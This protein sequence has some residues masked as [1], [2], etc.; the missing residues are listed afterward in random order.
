MSKVDI[1]AVAETFRSE[2]KSQI[3]KSGGKPKLVAFLCSKD[4]S[5]LQYAEFTKK[6][7]TRDGIEFV[8]QEVARTDLE[9]KII[10]ANEDSSIHGILVYYPVFGGAMDFYL[11]DVVA[12]EKDVEGMNNRCRFNLY[13]NI[14]Y[15]DEAKTKKCILPCTAIA[16]VKIIDSA[17]IYDK[18]LPMGEHLKGKIVT[19]VNRSEIVGRPLAAMLANDGAFI[20]SFDINGCLEI[21]KGR[22][23]G[24]I[25]MMESEATLEQ[26]VRNSDILISGVPSDKFKIPT[27]WVKAN[28]LV[29]NFAYT[30]N[31]DT[32]ITEKCNYVSSIGRVTISMLE[33]NLMRLYENFHT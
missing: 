17:G 26:A 9:D 20:N 6:A 18:N 12:L 19:I 23:A 7:C 15:F 27:E 21:Q 10:E 25:K 2:V 24:T 4:P 3:E 33:R 30:K 1:G 28:T 31:F 22:V 14:R 11:Q 5:A 16:M 8:L 29:I 13:H 32:D